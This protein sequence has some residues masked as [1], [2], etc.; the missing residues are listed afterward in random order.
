MLE[1][2]LPRFN[3]FNSHYNSLTED[4][5]NKVAITFHGKNFTWNDLMAGLDNNSPHFIKIIKSINLERPRLIDSLDEKSLE[6]IKRFGQI[7]VS[8]KTG[9]KYIN[10]KKYAN[11]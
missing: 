9:K 11:S 8:K 1:Q 10:I 7:T 2:K 4:Q 3:R 5:K 6:V